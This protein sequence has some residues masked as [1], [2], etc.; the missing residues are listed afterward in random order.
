MLGDRSVTL[1]SDV[2]YL[3]PASEIQL[4]ELSKTLSRM[5]QNIKQIEANY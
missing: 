5:K 2:I 1:R 4:S 3:N